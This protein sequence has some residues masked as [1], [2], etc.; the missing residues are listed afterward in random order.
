MTGA[1]AKA[2]AMEA[3]RIVDLKIELMAFM[4]LLLFRKID[5]KLREA[6][7]WRS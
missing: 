4:R 3:T 2:S 6:A 1:T 7:K 5:R